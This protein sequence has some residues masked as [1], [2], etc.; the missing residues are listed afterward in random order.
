MIAFHGFQLVPHVKVVRSDGGWPSWIDEWAQPLRVKGVLDHH[1]H[2]PFGLH[3]VRDRKMH[4]DQF[5]L[6]CRHPKASWLAD[7]TGF[8]S[9]V[10][11][12]HAAG[13]T[14]AAYVGSPLVIPPTL[15]DV[16]LPECAPG[17]LPLATRLRVMRQLH[18]C[19]GIPGARCLCWSPL[20]RHYIKP[21]LD[22][23]VDRIGFDF[24]AD[25]RPG[26]CMDQLVRG[27][28]AARIEV[29]IEPWPLRDR[30]YPPVAWIIRE[31]RFQRVR[32][33]PRKDEV[34]L[35]EMTA[36][37]YRIVPSH[38]SEDGKAEIA[39]I[40]ELLAPHGEGPI[41]FTQELV[42]RV[43]ADGHTPL[44]RARQLLDGSVA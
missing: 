28:I 16:R 15:R 35:N 4:V 7:T 8:A 30:P 2:N 26:S 36:P 22:A 6:T 44:V 29:M 37:I 33:K 13:G 1:L 9:A 21:L 25:F 14:V 40:N 41:V 38:E 10:A 34:P 27:L 12:V 42:D 39:D 24:S 23:R 11:G 19:D 5:E 43:I 32:L 18:L 31:V 3:D 17:A 20:I